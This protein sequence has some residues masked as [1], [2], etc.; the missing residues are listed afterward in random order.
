[1]RKFRQYY[2]FIKLFEI[3]VEE[4]IDAIR[5]FFLHHLQHGALAFLWCHHPIRWNCWIDLIELNIC[6]VA[7]KSSKQFDVREQICLPCAAL[8]LFHW[9][10]SLLVHWTRMKIISMNY[11]SIICVSFVFWNVTIVSCFFFVL[12]H[13]QIN[14]KIKTHKSMRKPNECCNVIIFFSS[15]KHSSSRCVMEIL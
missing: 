2:L 6:T 5:F 13:S 8:S 3:K 7:N 1:M 10:E 15:P 12:F 11:N 9:L 4:K 14:S